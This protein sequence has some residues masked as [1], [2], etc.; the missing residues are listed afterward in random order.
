MRKILLLSSLITCG[1][2]SAQ[3]TKLDFYKDYLKTNLVKNMEKEFTYKMYSK[4]ILNSLADS[5]VTNNYSPCVIEG[6]ESTDDS[7]QQSK[8][9]NNLNALTETNLDQVL[10]DNNLCGLFGQT[11]YL[12]KYGSEDGILENGFGEVIPNDIFLVRFNDGGSFTND[13]YY[14]IES[15]K[16][17]N[18]QIEPTEDFFELVNKKIKSKP[19]SYFNNMRWTTGTL[20]GGIVKKIDH[21]NYLISSPI[22]NE[23]YT[24]AYDIEFKT[25]DFKKFVPVRVRHDEQSKWINFK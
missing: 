20:H 22:Y 25:K 14:K 1:I 2:L 18:V 8:F 23:D 5:I 16:L 3:I 9:I 11:P 6:F 19:K 17:I 21:E 4:S 24:D 15:N 7:I 13:Q 12:S 10:I